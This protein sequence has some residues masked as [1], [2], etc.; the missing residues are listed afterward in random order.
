[1][2]RYSAFIVCECGKLHTTT[3]INKNTNCVCGRALM[4]QMKFAP[5]QCIPNNTNFRN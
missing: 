4:P 5:S 3:Y 2:D 1:M